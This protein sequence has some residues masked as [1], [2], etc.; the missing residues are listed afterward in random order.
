MACD[1]NVDADLVRNIGGGVRAAAPAFA[2][3]VAADIVLELFEG[4]PEVDANA[5]FDVFDLG[6]RSS[7]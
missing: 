5:G 7:E 3:V 1:V 2:L 6:D 4:N